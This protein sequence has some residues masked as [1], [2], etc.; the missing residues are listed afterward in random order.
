LSPAACARTASDLTT[1]AHRLDRAR[2]A[3][4]RQSRLPEEDFGG[5]SGD[6]FRRH[7]ARSATTVADAAADLTVLAGAVAA[8]GHGP[9][10]AAELRDLAAGSP[11][12]QAR[13][14]RVLARDIER[15]G[16]QRWREAVAT[17]EGAG[18]P[19]SSAGPPPGGPERGEH[20]GPGAGAG[21]RT[22]PPARR[23][24]VR[25]GPATDRGDHLLA[26]EV[27]DEHR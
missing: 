24:R 16:Q 9:A 26:P 17:Y 10:A 19:S 1:L 22:A 5:L 25:A 3:L 2:A 7:V 12:E 14:L 4:V 6:A 21:L 27:V 11:P 20:V 18:Q 8:L 15:R 13:Q 23:S